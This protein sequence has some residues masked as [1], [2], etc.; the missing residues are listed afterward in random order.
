MEQLNAMF[1]MNR[2]DADEQHPLGLDG[3][4]GPW[5]EQLWRRLAECY[6]WSTE[7][8]LELSP[9]VQLIPAMEKSHS[10]DEPDPFYESKLISNKRITSSDHFQDV[11]HLIFQCDS[12]PKYSPGDVAVFKPINSDEAIQELLKVLGW[13]SIADIQYEIIPQRPGVNL[14]SRFSTL[15]DLF[16]YHLDITSPP[17]RVFF[18]VAS[19][20]VKGSSQD[21]NHTNTHDYDL[22]REKL[23]ELSSAKGL[24]L[25]LDYVYRP[26]RTPA[27]VLSDFSLII[28]VEYIFDLFPLQRPREYSI[29]SFSQGEVHICA[30]IVEYRTSLKKSRMGVCSRWFVNLKS[31]EHVFLGIRHGTWTLPPPTTP[32]IL[33][34]AGTGIAPMRAIIQARSPAPTYLFFGCRYLKRD[35]HYSE[36]WKSF[37]GLRVFALGSR[38]EPGAR[39]HIDQLLLKN[40][41]LIKQ[42][43]DVGAIV[44]MAGNSKLPTLIKKTLS[45]ICNDEELPKILERSNRL[46]IEA[47]S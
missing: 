6:G 36:E 12:F 40:S 43:I 22:H 3:T 8:I 32:V 47:W 41:N 46:F 42:L 24:D 15:T 5:S 26:K 16:R 30:A 1:I 34:A 27:E 13:S 7:I 38:D 10:L 39:R 45:M 9:K 14:P 35:Y 28:P 11:R 2:A 29:A 4:Y 21:Q 17:K 19:R 37:E 44:Y 33:I 20:H 25:Y 23:E 31:D 18:E